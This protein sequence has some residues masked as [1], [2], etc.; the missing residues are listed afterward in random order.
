MDKTDEEVLELCKAWFED[1]IERSD[2][3]T[4]GNVSHERASIRGVAKNYAEFVDEYLKERWKPSEQDILLLEKI[5]DGKIV[6]RVYQV[7]LQGIIEQLKKLRRN[8]L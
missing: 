8:R 7:T 3:L 2:R 1:I 4:S 6:T 5:F